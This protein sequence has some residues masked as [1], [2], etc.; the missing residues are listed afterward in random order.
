L[1]ERIDTYLADS[2]STDHLGLKRTSAATPTLAFLFSGQGGQ[3]AG[4][5]RE[6][7]Q[8]EAVFYQA[9]VRID[10]LMQ[11]YVDWSVIDLLRQ[12]QSDAHFNAI[13]RIQPAIFAIQVALVELWQHWGITPEAVV[14]HSL[15]EVA[16]AYCAG[17]LNLEDAV[18]VVCLR[19][20]HLKSLSGRGGM[21]A[22]ELSAAQATAF[23]QDYGDEVVLAAV[24]SPSSTVLAGDPAMLQTIL[25][26][27][28]AQHLFAKLVQ[29]DVASHSPQIDGIRSELLSDLQDITSQPA[30]LPFYSTVSGGRDEQLDFTANYWFDNLRKPVLFA[31]ALGQLLADE[32]TVLVEIGPHPVLLG[33]AQQCLDPP[34]QAVSLL[35]SLRRDTP[36]RLSLLQALGVLYTEGFPTRWQRLFPAARASYPLPP[37]RWQ[38]QRYWLDNAHTEWQQLRSPEPAAHPLLGGRISLAH[39]PDTC[40]WQNMITLERMSY[41][42][43]HRVAGE[44]ILPAAAYLEM[45]LGAAKEID[46][47]PSYTLVDL[48]FQQKMSLAP[49]QHQHLQTVLVPAEHGRFHFQV[50]SRTSSEEDW[51]LHHTA[52]FLSTQDSITPA[53][54]DS[55]QQV[56]EVLDTATSRVSGEQFYHSWLPPALEYGADFRGLQELWLS[57]TTVVGRIQLP[58]NLAYDQT[59]YQIHPALLDAG[60]QL[61]A[62]L[63]GQMHDHTLHLPAECQEMSFKSRPSDEVWVSVSL[64]SSPTADSNSVEIDLHLFDTH[65]RPCLTLLGLRLQRSTG[66]QSVSPPSAHTWLYT[67]QWQAKAEENLPSSSGNWLILADEQGFGQ[68]LAETLTRSGD[69][70]SLLYRRELVSD[71][72]DPSVVLLTEKLSA[73]SPFTGIVYLWGICTARPEQDAPDIGT[74]LLSLIQALTNS[75]SSSPR[76]YLLTRGA[77]AVAAHEVPA[78]NQSVLWGLGKVISFELPALKCTRIDLDPEID[79][80]RSVSHLVRQLRQETTED[81]IAL[82]ADRRLVLRLVPFLPESA[83]PAGESVIRADATYLITGGLGALGLHT[84]L[85]LVQA[86][87]RQLVLLGRSPASATASTLIERMRTSGAQV[88]IQT[89]DVSDATQLRRVFAEIKEELPPLRGIVHAAG[90]LDDGALS[91]LNRQRL[92]K[93]MAPKVAGTWN[94]HEASLSLEL[95][96]LVLYSS[97]V[98]VLGSPGQGNYAAASSYLDTMAHYRQSQGLPAISINWGPWAEVGLAAEATERLAAADASTQHLVKV[99]EIAEGLRVFAQLLSS[100]APQV[101]ALPFDLQHLLELYP[102]AASMPFFAEVGGSKTHS[103]HLYARPQLRQAYVAPRNDIERK[104]AELWQQTLHIDRVGIHDS[105]FELGGDS[106]LATQVLARARKSY[107]ISISPREAFQSFT[108]EKLAELLEAEILR[109]LEDMSEEE[110]QRLLSEDQ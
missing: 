12:E 46:L 33:A 8:K 17:I 40:I 55:W 94:L 7:L 79:V 13:D 87:A 6:L 60:L 103:A 93:V 18:Q 58:P 1:T 39:A 91:N 54:T 59:K 75:P 64:R 57:K 16:A 88:K 4:M 9:V 50:Y 10:T 42:Q 108:I 20:K 45:A 73:L 32:Y 41:L 71:S 5:G 27:L 56:A 78:L 72:V 31:D 76:L 97:A 30:R 63:D 24:N 81:Q 106:V 84:A 21:L 11:K 80:A 109:Q 37:I 82:R 95:D 70:C 67:L 14:G 61:I 92:E 2:A 89:A 35:P 96:F 23:L 99:I 101:V 28:E 19:S 74:D 22:T 52:T 69:N 105:F 83:T 25:D 62:A 53:T 51:R 77:Q 36:A 110:A 47:P 102:S 85:W 66:R 104:L 34:H 68:A 38:R 29:V 15:G 98:S 43:D 48:T 90:L 49:G 3:W 86:G 100:P 107:G 44:C 26:T 65:Q